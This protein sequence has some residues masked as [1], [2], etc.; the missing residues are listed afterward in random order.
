[1]DNE[2]QQTGM[3]DTNISGMSDNLE[4]FLKSWADDETDP[5]DTAKMLHSPGGTQYQGW[6][7]QELLAAY[8]NG[9]LNPEF[10]S[11]ACNRTFENQDEIGEWLRNIWQPW[12]DQPFPIPEKPQ[13][14][15]SVA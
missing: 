14:D 12:F 15:T 7:S 3:D 1:M 13:S 6:L 2:V 5:A 11:V 4:E 8:Q 10:L 9:S